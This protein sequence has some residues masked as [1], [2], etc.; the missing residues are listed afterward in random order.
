MLGFLTILSLPPACSPVGG[1][2]SFT[3]VRPRGKPVKVAFLAEFR[4]RTRRDHCPA[5][6]RRRAGDFR[7]GEFLAA[8]AARLPRCRSR[9][10]LL[11]KDF[12]PAAASFSGVSARD[13]LSG[14]GEADSPIGSGF[15]AGD[16]GLRQFNPRGGYHKAAVDQDGEAVDKPKWEK[17]GSVIRRGVPPR[18]VQRFHLWLQGG[19]PPNPRE[20]EW[21]GRDCAIMASKLEMSMMT[22]SG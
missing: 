14:R 1:V 12:G 5:N 6:Y 3:G 9:H 20:V 4:R 8:A 7:P 21:W 10:S 16:N 18:I 17:V 22:K 11:L 13:A 15:C 2:V 19:E